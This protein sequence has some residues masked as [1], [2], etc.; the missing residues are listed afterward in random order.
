MKV[1]FAAFGGRTA[2]A[3]SEIALKMAGASSANSA[4]PVVSMTASAV[5]N[6]GFHDSVLAGLLTIGMTFFIVSICF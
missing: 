2:R 5:A 3:A 6:K 4:P 1:N